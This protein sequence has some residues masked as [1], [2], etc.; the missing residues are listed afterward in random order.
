MEY[1]DIIDKNN[2]VV[3]R[4]SKKDI[5]AKKLRHRIVHVLVFNSQNK[6]LLQQRDKSCNYLPLGWSTSVGGHVQSEKLYKQAA[7]RETKE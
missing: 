1:L 5:Y 4:A 6:I 7:I 2:K 3:S